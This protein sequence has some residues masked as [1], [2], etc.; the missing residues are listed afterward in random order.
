MCTAAGVSGVPG[1][2][3]GP[4][5][6][7]STWGVVSGSDPRWP[8]VSRRATASGVAGGAVQWRR[9]LDGRAR[10][11]RVGR[12][13]FRR[14]GPVPAADAVLVAGGT[15]I[16]A[17]GTGVDAEPGGG[18]VS[19][20]KQPRSRGRIAG[21]RGAA[22]V[23]AVAGASRSEPGVGGVAA[24][25]AAGR[26]DAGCRDPGN[27][28]LTGDEN[29]VSGTCPRLDEALERGRTRRKDA[30]KDARKDAK[31]GGRKEKPRFCAG[32]WNA[33]SVLWTRK[34]SVASRPPIAITF[35]GGRNAS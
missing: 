5:G 34:R 3:H 32:N 11:R 18:T 22:G 28:K 20:G 30:K 19:A 24:A 25:V 13:R 27:R 35:S 29:H 4:C 26:A 23:A 21:R 16:A 2:L 31:K 17:R 8:I 6:F 1:P 12:N 9:S 33:G 7:W 10:D 15:W 14:T